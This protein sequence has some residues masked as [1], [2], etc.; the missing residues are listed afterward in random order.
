M[1]LLDRNVTYLVNLD[2]NTPNGVIKKPIMVKYKEDVKKNGDMLARFVL[3][4]DYFELTNETF[5]I[6]KRQINSFIDRCCV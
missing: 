4:N 1:K 5:T 6:K 3:V 2:I